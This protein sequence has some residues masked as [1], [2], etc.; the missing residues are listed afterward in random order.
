MKRLLPLAL[1]VALAACQGASQPAPGE[2]AADSAASAET[3]TLSSVQEMQEY[4]DYQDSI[5]DDLENECNELAR[6][7]S[8]YEEP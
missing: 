6:R 4:I 5:I 1:A 3:L 2:A 7:L 8:K